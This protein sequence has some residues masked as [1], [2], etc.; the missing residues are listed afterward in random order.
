MGHYT[1]N[2]R[3]IEFALFDLLG[4]E[5]ILGTGPFADIDR[6]TAM[7]MLE[8]LKRPAPSCLGD[9]TGCRSLARSTWGARYL[10]HALGMDRNGRPSGR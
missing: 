8:E 7:G 4:R 3:D 6:D 5:K 2:L 10:G 9:H 1:A